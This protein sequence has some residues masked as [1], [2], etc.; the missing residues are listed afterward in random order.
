LLVDDIETPRAPV[1][2]MR[3]RLA[4]GGR[5]QERERFPA[6]VR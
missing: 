5:L 2:S 1:I 3:D 6:T 4:R